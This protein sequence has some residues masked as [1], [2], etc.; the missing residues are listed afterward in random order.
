MASFS[1]SPHVDAERPQSCHDA[2]QF[3]KPLVHCHSSPSHAA[4]H[5]SVAPLEAHQPDAQVASEARNED[6]DASSSDLTDL[7]ELS[8]DDESSHSG[9]SG[10]DTSPSRPRCGQG[11]SGAPSR[12]PNATRVNRPWSQKDDAVLIASFKEHGNRWALVQGD[13]DKAGRPWRSTGTIEGRFSLLLAYATRGQRSNTTTASTSSSTQPQST[14]N[15]TAAS[16]ASA[17]SLLHNRSKDERKKPWTSQEVTKLV[18]IAKSFPP[19]RMY[20]E[21]C[22]AFPNAMRTEPAVV[23]KWHRLRHGKQ[24]PGRVRGGGGAAREGRGRGKAVVDGVDDSEEEEGDEEKRSAPVAGANS[25]S[26]STMLLNG[27]SGRRTDHSGRRP[28]A[29]PI[30][31]ATTQA[32]FAPQGHQAVAERAPALHS[33]TSAEAFP[34]R[35]QQRPFATRSTLP[36]AFT[37]PRLHPRHSFPATKAAAPPQLDLHVSIEVT[38]SGFVI[39]DLP[40]GYQFRVL[41]PEQCQVVAPTQDVRASAFSRALSPSVR[42]MTAAPFAFQVQADEAIEAVKLPPGTK[43]SIGLVRKAGFGS[44]EGELC[45]ETSFVSA[46]GFIVV[47]R[48]RMRG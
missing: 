13:L 7:S 6:E 39:T 48:S 20:E 1:S 27:Q 29:T 44:K 24:G 32:S 30:T 9:D 38:S 34:H 16:L 43:T 18:E 4:H 31:T 37:P 25:S 11:K 42:M 2:E 46:D 33:L 5:I 35:I 15:T 47:F 21:W 26:A 28:F 14:I 19:A 45:V 22:R 40:P 36:P 12:P 10:T 3:F 41:S 17:S 23:G 8:E